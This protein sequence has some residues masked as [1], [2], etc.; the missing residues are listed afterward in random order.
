MQEN[1]KIGTA[2]L[3]GYLLG[4]TK[5]AKAAISLA[6]WLS[7]KGRPRDF[8]RDQAAKALQS[9]RGQELM[10]Q[11][12][13]PVMSAGR[14]AALS[15]FEAQAGRLGENLQRRTDDLGEVTGGA[16]AGKRGRGSSKQTAERL[17][18]RRRQTSRQ[19]DDS[20]RPNRRRSTADDV[21]EQDSPTGEEDQF[22]DE[23]AAEDDAEYDDEQAPEDEGLDEDED[24]AEEDSDEYEDEEG[25]EDEYDDEEG[26]QDE[27]EDEEGVEDEYDDEEG[28][29]DDT[30]VPADGPVR[31]P[32]RRARERISA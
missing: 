2:A 27:Y 7:G 13:G 21:E 28:A 9:D 26:A 32:R 31:R 16:S 18:E 22:E 4:R 20:R 19:P 29:E 5:K 3:G 23:Y 15:V 11:L 8:L 30:D 6:L 24:V 17:S 14:Q 25:V 10:T 1:V 12:R